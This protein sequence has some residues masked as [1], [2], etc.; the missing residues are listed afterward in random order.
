MD[1]TTDIPVIDIFTDGRDACAAVDIQHNVYMW[2]LVNPLGKAQ[3]LPIDNG[4][5]PRPTKLASG[6]SK[7]FPMV[8]TDIPRVDKDSVYQVSAD[9][10]EHINDT[11]TTDLVLSIGGKDVRVHKA[12]LQIRSEYFKAMFRNK[13]SEAKGDKI[14]LDEYSYDVYYAYLKY[15]YT[16]KL[17]RMNFEV[18]LDFIDFA[19]SVLDECLVHLAVEYIM[20]VVNFE[21]VVQLFSFAVENEKK[22]LPDYSQKYNKELLD[23]SLRFLIR[24]LDEFLN[25]K[26]FEDMPGDHEKILIR[27]VMQKGMCFK[28]KHSKC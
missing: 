22:K 25:S 5:Y 8:F 7:C 27:K 16:G 20:K 9:L 6:A 19:F 24:C 2:G 15:I 26:A 12:V 14:I 17:E 13:W 18:T 11:E 1:S 4:R 21:D 23:Y 28:N 3:A 10:F